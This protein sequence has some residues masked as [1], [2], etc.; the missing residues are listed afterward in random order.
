[1]VPEDRQDLGVFIRQSIS[2]NTT[3]AIPQQITNSFGFINS[4]KEREK[5]KELVDLLKTRYTNLNQMVRDLS[6]GNQQKVSLAKW[7]AVE[8]NILILDEPTRGID[9]GAKAEV[10]KIIGELAAQGKCILMISSEIEEV[11]GLSDRIMVMYEGRQTAI[12]ENSQINEET[13]LLAAHNEI[14]SSEEGSNG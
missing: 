3:F 13:V 7:L 14:V 9:V 8:P 1:M 10:Y 5:S 6:G 4:K 11:L 2:F 12:L